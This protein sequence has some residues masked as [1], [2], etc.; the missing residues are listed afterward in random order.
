MVQPD[1][2]RRT[3]PG[4]RQSHPVRPRSPRTPLERQGPGRRNP[5]RVLV[6]GGPESSR[7]LADLFARLQWT[8][9]RTADLNSVRGTE[10]SF[11]LVFIDPQ[12]ERETHTDLYHVARARWPG[13]R[14]VPVGSRSGGPPNGRPRSRAPRDARPV[15]GEPGASRP[16]APRPSTPSKPGESFPHDL[17]IARLKRSPSGEEPHGEAEQKVLRIDATGAPPRLLGRLLVGGYITGQDRVIVTAPNDLTALQREEIQK[18]A[19]RVLGMSVVA[20]R[21]GRVEV[22]S[23]LDPSKYGFVPLLNRTVWMLRAQLELCRRALDGTEQ[24]FLPDVEEVEEGVDRLY[25][26]MVRQLLLS[27]DSPSIARRVEVESRHYQIGDRL[28]AK[29]LEVIGDLIREIGRELAAHREEFP[30]LPPEVARQLPGLIQQF[31]SLLKRTAEA[32]VR[33]SPFEANTLLDEIQTL[34]P[35]DSNLGDDFARQIADPRLAIAVER[36]VWSLVLALDMLVVVN[37]V[38]INRS[39]EPVSG[40]GSGATLRFPEPT[41]PSG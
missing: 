28:V 25:L 2:K 39:V 16:Q 24:D 32:F 23:F 17:G 37:E 21:P 20:D 33:T 35:H 12:R 10:T 14:V 9:V 7:E 36:V 8:V 34:L 29:V 40:G 38:T 3:V 18:T 31:D 15:E 30:T 22:Q 4:S 26:L 13:A 1:S 6:V 19:H 5:L 11:D 27:C 41:G